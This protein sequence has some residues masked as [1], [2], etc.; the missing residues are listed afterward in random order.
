MIDFHAI[1]KAFNLETHKKKASDFGQKYMAKAI[2]VLADKFNISEISRKTGVERHKTS[3]VLQAMD[4]EPLVDRGAGGFKKY[5]WSTAD[6]KLFVDRMERKKG[7]E[8]LKMYKKTVQNRRYDR[9]VI[10]S[11]VIDHIERRLGI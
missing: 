11:E 10:K 2:Y 9:G 6:E 3:L 7:V 5:L 4:K 1:D 8:W